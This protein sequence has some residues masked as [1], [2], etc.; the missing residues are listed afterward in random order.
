MNGKQKS[1]CLSVFV[2]VLMTLPIA[3]KAQSLLVGTGEFPP[4]ISATEEGGGPIAQIVRQAF[5]NVGID[6]QARYL[7]WNRSYAMARDL[8]LDASFPW[9]PN[10]Q[11]SSDFYFSDPLYRFQRRGYVLAGSKLNIVKDDNIQM[12]HPIGYER[13]GYESELLKDNRASL[14]ETPD[15]AQCFVMLKAKRV[16]VVVS[17]TRES[18]E[19]IKKIFASPDDVTRLEQVLHE[20]DNHLV[21]SKKHPDAAKILQQFNQGLQQLKLSGRYQEIIQA[22]KLN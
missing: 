8:K 10:T 9:S 16:D 19:Y 17:E 18:Q 15:M 22:S 12:C 5:L 21:V 13:L 7:P 14:I 20:Y 1:I 4:Y 3:S 2:F 11:R 6:I